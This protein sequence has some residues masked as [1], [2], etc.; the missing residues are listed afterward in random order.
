MAGRAWRGGARCVHERPQSQRSCER[1][2]P[3]VVPSG[4]GPGDGPACAGGLL[5]CGVALCERTQADGEAE[6]RRGEASHAEQGA[7]QS[8]CAPVREPGQARA[9]AVLSLASARRAHAPSNRVVHRVRLRGR[10]GR[11]VSLRR[12]PS[13]VAPDEGGA[14]FSD[15][16][17]R[18]AGASFSPPAPPPPPVAIA[19]AIA[20]RPSRI[21]RCGSACCSVRSC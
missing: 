15:L 7:F 18:G 12:C 19:I 1:K 9:P 3:Y 20:H 4:A 21:G 17:P 5:E 2:A 10:R 6:I 13:F 16:P 11:A 8:D 14:P